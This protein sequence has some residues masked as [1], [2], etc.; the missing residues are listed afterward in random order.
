MKNIKL[1]KVGLMAVLFNLSINTINA[2]DLDSINHLKNNDS[3]ELSNKKNASSK[4]EDEFN[5]TLKILGFTAL[6]AVGLGGVYIA[7]ILS[8]MV[9][10][11]KPIKRN[12]KQQNNYDFLEA[13][14][15]GDLTKIKYFLNEESVNINQEKDLAISRACRYGH[16]D[17]VKYLLNAPELK[18]HSNIYTNNSLA[19]T[20][21]CEHNKKEIIQ[22]L[23]FDYHIDKNK[24]IKNYIKNNPEIAR[25]FEQRE[26]NIQLNKELHNNSS[27]KKR[28]KL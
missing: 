2:K 25:M 11:S 7:Y 23:I 28:N 8:I 10:A 9:N 18:K 14:S 12:H 6:G 21:A 4:Q 13:C 24:D 17:I 1:L 26:L 16:L 15:Q 19:F 5:K 20:T 22:Y 3:S 27:I